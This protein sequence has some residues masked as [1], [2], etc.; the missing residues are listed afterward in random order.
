LRKQT[1]QE[2]RELHGVRKGEYIL[3]VMMEGILLT[4]DSITNNIDWVF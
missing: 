4:L 1:E 3:R 2:V